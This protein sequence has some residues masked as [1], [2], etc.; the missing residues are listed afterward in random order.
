MSDVEFESLF[1][2]PLETRFVRFLNISN[3]IFVLILL[4]NSILYYLK[5]DYW[6]LSIIKLEKILLYFSLT[7]LIISFYLLKSRKQKK[8]GLKRSK[9]EVIKGFL[10]FYLLSLFFSSSF[11]SLDYFYGLITKENT[12][13]TL[14]QMVFLIS[15]PFFTLI[16][17]NIRQKSIKQLIEPEKLLDEGLSDSSELKGLE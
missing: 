3:I 2:H 16:L 10:N 9:I 7:Y 8:L 15:V 5:N 14:S 12:F 6:D 17:L 11:F 13:N 1:K 4:L